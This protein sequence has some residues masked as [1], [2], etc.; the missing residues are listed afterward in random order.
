[1]K[2]I[3]I[4]LMLFITITTKAQVGVGTTIPETS[5]M[6]E[7]KSTSKGFLPPRMTFL[8]R[9]SINVTASSAGLIV[10]CIDCGNGELQGYN[11]T[12]WTNM[13][14][15]A[16][17]TSTVVIG[18]SYKGGKVAY[19][20]QNGDPGYVAGQVHGLI[21]ANTDQSNLVTWSNGS[22]TNTS[23]TGINL[24]TGFL[25]TN[26]IITS[27]GNTGSYA[28]KLCRDYTGG[29]YTDWYLPSKDELNK[30]YINRAA[31]G[32]FANTDANYWSSSEFSDSFAWFQDFS[33][34]G[35]YNFFFDKSFAMRVR[36]VRAF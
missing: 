12:T 22:N 30:L 31:I 19:I 23:A 8:Q 35:Q 7:V 5:A 14:G 20:L 4:G 6:L 33:N 32:G 28:A 1:M 21:A 25:N 11:G 16:A 10:Y 27:Q 29:G 36:A 34:G 26:K 15:G 18:Q 2:H 17:S 13:I 9:N 24:G 3:L